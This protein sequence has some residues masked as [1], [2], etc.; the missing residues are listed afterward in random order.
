VGG[1]KR[2]WSTAAPKEF[3][4]DRVT[5]TGEL[6]FE[7]REVH[8]TELG[9][10]LTFTKPVDRVSGSEAANYL[11]KQF[12]YRYHQDYGSPEFDHSGKLGATETPVT[13]VELSPNGLVARLKIPSLRPG[14]VT[15]VQLAVSTTA[16]EDL[17]NDTFYYTLNN[18][19]AHQ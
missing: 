6:P 11:V 12:A 2:T 14:Y 9:F 3:S 15:S 4:L 17:R 10:D 16:D 8:A 18:R 5:F 13:S 19:P 7:V 1:G